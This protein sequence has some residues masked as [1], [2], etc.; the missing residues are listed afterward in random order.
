MTIVPVVN[1][2]ISINPVIRVIE[3]L[4]FMYILTVW[5]VIFATVILCNNVVIAYSYSMYMYFM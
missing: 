4:V 2:L 3:R 1:D 5:L